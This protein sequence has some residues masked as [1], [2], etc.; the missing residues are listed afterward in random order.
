L[1]GGDVEGVQW[2]Q[3]QAE[4]GQQVLDFLPPEEIELFDG[5]MVYP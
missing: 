4:A 2:I 1:K 5:E 3:E